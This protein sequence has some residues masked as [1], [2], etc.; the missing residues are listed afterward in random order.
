MR[1][2][3][4]KF[5]S[6]Y[7]TVGKSLHRAS[8]LRRRHAD[9][10]QVASNTYVNAEKLLHVAEQLAQSGDCDPHEIYQVC[11]NISFKINCL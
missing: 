9:F 6:K 1:E 8:L 3:G 7:T 10:E 2:H 5:L 11:G 4:E